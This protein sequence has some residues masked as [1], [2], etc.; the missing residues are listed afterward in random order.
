M[1]AFPEKDGAMPVSA[2]LAA[3]LFIASLAI[4]SSAAGAEL[5]PRV[6]DVTLSQQSVR[7]SVVDNGQR[8]HIDWTEPS[9]ASAAVHIDATSGVAR[10]FF[11]PTPTRLFVGLNTGGR[12]QRA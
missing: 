1:A 10:R 2:H 7:M 5:K 8:I 4:S 6:L 12:G 3:G 9:G 11:D